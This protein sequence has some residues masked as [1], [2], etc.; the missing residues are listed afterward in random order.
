MP[1]QYC[2][3]APKTPISDATSPFTDRVATLGDCGITRLYKDGIGAAYRAAKSMAVTAIFDG[4]SADDFRNHY[5]KTCRSISN[6]N[7]YGKVIFAVTQKIQ[8]MEFAR[9]AIFKTVADEQ[10]KEG[11]NRRMS[12]IFWDTFTGS[13]HYRDVFFRMMHPANL[14]YLITNALYALLPFRK[15]NNKGDC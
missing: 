4:I 1:E 5:W 14:W 7:R 8:R 9:Q 15:R 3:C 13:A 11:T 10:I 12:M 2:H 6:D